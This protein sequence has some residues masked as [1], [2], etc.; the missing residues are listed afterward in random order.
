MVRE[1]HHNTAVA[2]PRPGGTFAKVARVRFNQQVCDGFI[3]IYIIFLFYFILLFEVF[4]FILFIYLFIY[5]FCL[6]FVFV[7]L[8]IFFYLCHYFIFLIYS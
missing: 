3:Y 1:W 4:I 8:F 7:F 5:F 2:R 6:C